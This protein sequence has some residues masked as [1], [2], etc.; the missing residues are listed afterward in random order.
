MSRL[1]LNRRRR[2]RAEVLEPRLAL[3]LYIVNLAGDALDPNPSDGLWDVDPDTAGIQL[4]FAA[5]AQAINN[6]GNGG[7]TI[8]FGIDGT[9]S[10]V[11]F[12]HLVGIDGKLHNIDLNGGTIS[13]PAGGELINAKIAHGAIAITGNN[14]RVE[15]NTFTTPAQPA[16]IRVIGNTATIKNNGVSGGNVVVQGNTASLQY[17]SISLGGVQLTGNNNTL[18]NS[19][20]LQS[21]AAGVLI[22]GIGNRVEGNQIG[23][24]NDTDLGNALDGVAID[25]T[26]VPSVDNVIVGNL[27]S[28]NGGNGVAIRGAQATNNSVQGNKIGTNGAGTAAIAN[29]LAGVLIADSHDNTIGG[30]TVGTGNVIS[31]NTGDGVRITGSTSYEN[32]LRSNIIGLN[33]G[34]NAKLANGGVGVAI[35]GGHDNDIGVANG[36]NIIS[37]NTSHGVHLSADAFANTLV[38]NV[39]GTSAN[40]PAGLGNG[41]D[42]VLIENAQ[43]NIINGSTAANRISGNAG[44]GVRIT[45]VNAT[46]NVIRVSLIGITLANTAL[47]NLQGGVTISNGASENVVGGDA[48]G[49]N[50]IAGNAQWGIAINGASDNRI[51]G[52]FIGTNINGTAAVGAQPVGVLIENSAT[53]N[54]VG[55]GLGGTQNLISGNAGDGV[56]IRGLGTNNNTITGNF[57]GLSASI[58]TGVPNGG[59]GIRVHD[60]A[61]Q[62]ILGVQSTSTDQISVIASNVLGGIALLNQANQNKVMNN[63]IGYSTTETTATFANTGPGITIDNSQ[64]NVI[65]GSALGTFNVLYGN[66]GEGVLVRNG[67]LG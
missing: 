58:E 29:S 61:S 54:L 12:N 7:G 8:E 6:D 33:V 21:P 20:V 19:V 51:S 38:G 42:G 45:G 17:N 9:F 66:G 63:R 11:T 37:G 25:G 2:L 46:E 65:G 22:V 60:R 1:A 10:G 13:M 27:I 15:H 52:N 26:T 49:R 24:T 55:F 30:T 35:V 48:T 50:Y 44:S 31:G 23:V 5:A 47:P 64:N 43:Q 67:S 53:N 57:I 34:G 59:Y 40:D 18:L 39:I 14:A 16:A 28:G 4:T 3:A 41:G 32:Q 36:G 62:N 56:E